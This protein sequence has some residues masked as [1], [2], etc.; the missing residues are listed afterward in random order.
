MPTPLEIRNS[1]LKRFY[2]IYMKST[3]ARV[4]YGRSTHEVDEQREIEWLIG[5]G[6]LE[7]EPNSLRLSVSGREE[8][9]RQLAHGAGPCPTC[10][11]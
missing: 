3:S 8:Y 6:W 9:E 2:D 1:L 10:G 4:A 11:R 7:H 5:Q